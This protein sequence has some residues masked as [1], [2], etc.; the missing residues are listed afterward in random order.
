MSVEVSDCSASP[1]GVLT[2][3]PTR[4]T[5]KKAAP[6]AARIAIQIGARSRLISLSAARELDHD[7]GRLDRGDRTHPWLELQ[8]V[9]GLPRHQRHDPVRAGLHLDLCDHAI[10]DD[11][12]HDAWESIA[13]RLADHE[14]NPGDVVPWEQVKAEAL[15]RFRR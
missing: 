12:G 3:R 8:L 15:A 14:A 1:H 10:L 9:R 11:P 6:M 2:T 13:R 7:G 5:T 4:G